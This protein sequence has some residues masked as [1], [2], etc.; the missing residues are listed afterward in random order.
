MYEKAMDFIEIKDEIKDYNLFMGEDY[1]I[2][3]PRL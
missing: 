2:I 1:I 3:I